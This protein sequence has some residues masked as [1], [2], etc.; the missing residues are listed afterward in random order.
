MLPIRLRGARTHNLR[1]IDL[2]LPPGQLVALTGPS[3]AGKSSLAHRH[4]VRRGAAA[5]RREL[6]PLRAAV[7]R[8]ARAAPDRR[9]GAHRGDGRGRPAGAG[10]VEPVD[11]RDDG[12]PR[13][14]PRGALR[15]RGDSDVPRLRRRCG[16][17]ERHRRG[18]S[19]RRSAGR[20]AR[21][22]ELRGPRR[23]RRGVP[24]AARDACRRTGT[25]GSSSAGACATS[26]AC[27]RARRSRPA[28]GS[29]WWSTG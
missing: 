17:D 12:R 9:A 16:R 13:A 3:G 11:A 14:V 1:A 2:D 22:G 5:L 26:T 21:D 27:G 28:C 24:R 10:Q 7:P 6:Q 18:E 15:V 4:A 8:A 20:G 25:G 29:R 19:R 23:R